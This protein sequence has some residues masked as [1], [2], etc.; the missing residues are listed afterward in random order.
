[1]TVGGRAVRVRRSGGRLV[2][3]I[4]LRGRSSKRVTVRVMA[5]TRDGRTLREQRVYRLCT[6]R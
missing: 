6:R 4:D 2:A 3:R 5:R 1:V